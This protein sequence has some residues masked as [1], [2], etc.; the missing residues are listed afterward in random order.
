M[1]ALSL[2]RLLCEAVENEDT[3]EVDNL[4]KC[5]ANPNLVVPTGIAA[6][7]L[8][9]GKE[10]ESAL[11]CLIL[12]LQQ[13][14]DPN[15]RS[16]EL[17][18]P[19]HV[20][21][22]WGC[23]KALLHLLRK[24][25]DP[26]LQDQ[27][28]NAAYDL[29]LLEG[30]RRCV[31]ALQEY[32]AEWL[33]Q[34]CGF[35]NYDEVTQ[36]SNIS[37]LLEPTTDKSPYCSTKMSPFFLLCNDDHQ[38]K[39]INNVVITS[40]K[41][42]QGE[43]MKEKSKNEHIPKMKIRPIHSKGNFI[44]NSD[45]ISNDFCE[46]AL[47]DSVVLSSTKLSHT[48]N[49]IPDTFLNVGIDTISRDNVFQET[50]DVKEHNA[51]ENEYIL[52]CSVKHDS[53]IFPYSIQHKT[54][55]ELIFKGCNND[56]DSFTKNNLRS[57]K[58][59]IPDYTTC[60]DIKTLSKRKEGLDVTS[61][62]HVY[63]YN[64]GK[65]IN[66]D[67]EKTVNLNCNVGNNAEGHDVSSSSKYN[68]CE[69]DCYISLEESSSPSEHGKVSFK[70][71]GEHCFYTNKATCINHV[72]NQDR[73][74]SQPLMSRVSPLGGLQA[75]SF[76]ETETFVGEEA[77][78][79]IQ[80]LCGNNMHRLSHSSEF[81]T[82][83]VLDA[84]ENNCTKGCRSL[85]DQLRNMMLFT[86]EC[87]TDNCMSNSTQIIFHDLENLQVFSKT[88]IIDDQNQELNEK[89]KDIMVS[90]KQQVNSLNFT[91]TSDTLLVEP[92]TG[93]E[94]EE[95]KPDLNTKLKNMMIATKT[96]QNPSDQ[97]KSPCF[98]TPRTKSRL[99]SSSF[100][101][102]NSSLFDDLI[103]MP[104]RGRRIRSSDAQK[105]P[106]NSSMNGSKRE[107]LVTSTI[108]EQARISETCE[109]R[110]TCTPV[111]ND[112]VCISGSR[113]IRTVKTLGVDPMDFS[114]ILT[115]DHTSSDTE[116]SKLDSHLQHKSEGIVQNKEHGTAWLTEDGEEESCDEAGHVGKVID[117]S[118]QKS[119]PLLKSVLQNTSLNNTFTQD[120][121]TIKASRYS[122]S[123]YSCT[124]QSNT[125]VANSCQKKKVNESTAQ[126][127]QLSPGGRPLNQSAV[128]PVE[129]LYLDSEKGHA[130]I[131]R[132]VPCVDES[133]SEISENSDDTVIYDWR[134]YKSNQQ[135][136][137]QEPRAP[138]N[139]VAMELYRLSNNEIAS[140]LK[141]LGEEPG[142]VNSQNRKIFI[143]LLDKRM[144]ESHNKG[145]F[146]IT[147][148]TYEL[149]LALRT[150][151][152]P[153]CNTDE[154]ALS[155]EFDKPDKS[156]K[157]REGVLKSSFNYLLLDPR[158]TRNLPARCRTLSLPD[159]FRTFVNSIFYVGKGK[160]SRPYCHLYEA[161]TNYKNSKKQV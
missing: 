73:V 124:V 36:L 127:V 85:K 126:D 11:R 13:G 110:T 116:G 141:E 74:C 123:R 22:S 14:G 137:N 160:R 158:V 18:T 20:A 82:L 57:N 68:S 37:H 121:P 88:N 1:D 111:A 58:N 92:E 134:E 142:P 27:E 3:K 81:D 149:S 101:H 55:P 99:L 147:G 132:H 38:T 114:D 145:S 91:Q 64:R 25:G 130:L 93:V 87:K 102:S 159:C 52:N 103:E 32:E 133:V 56:V 90:T 29:A 144:K 84:S 51:S 62:D 95:E 40:Q 61:P 44:A 66:D 35:Q 83:S 115:D 161:L 151:Q 67:L 28:G 138:S 154:I 46:G 143:S 122:F 105:S 23:H 150:F 21:A 70:R 71:E 129:F 94:Q 117:S 39:G 16:I 7:H 59:A 113:Q 77:V 76:K 155:R 135:M 79:C 96:F 41:E 47:S 156:Q 119:V 80:S 4:L 6:M 8:A 42:T 97:I 50:N 26:T 139:K 140:R 54:R 69:S 104:H 148:Y 30:N 131:E 19:V 109:K 43:N 112:T 146:G 10:S 125:Q 153:D 78:A 75:Q 98:F 9:A 86:K 53:H 89:L 136:P 15:V 31:V 72:K 157:W 45:T 49:C 24:G 108:C 65:S 12:I 63:T 100:R 33:E 2:A 128:E 34:N 107:L 152:I 17:L 120:K 60:L 106:C 5:G 48:S 118:M